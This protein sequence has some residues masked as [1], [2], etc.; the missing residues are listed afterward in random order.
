MVNVT[1]EKWLDYNAHECQWFS[2]FA[3]TMCPCDNETIQELGLRHN[4]LVGRLPAQ[5]ALLTSL[6]KMDMM[7]NQLGST[8]PTEL[9]LLTNL[10][11]I[12]L[13]SNLFQ[14]KILND[15]FFMLGVKI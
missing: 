15:F 8:L 6:T 1:S 10:E 3:R 4:F 9:G 7:A 13:E 12:N 2:T 14:G 11:M 5:V